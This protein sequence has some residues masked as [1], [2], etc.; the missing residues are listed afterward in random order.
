MSDWN[1]S[2]FQT[3]EI[4]FGDDSAD[5]E[6]QK[7]SPIKKLYDFYGDKNANENAAKTPAAAAAPSLQKRAGEE[8]EQPEKKNKSYTYDL[9]GNILMTCKIEEWGKGFTLFGDFLRDA[10]KYYKKP[11]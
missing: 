7:S 6:Q 1:K 3:A 11:A 5:A 9:E 4:E 2:R 8:T 10:K